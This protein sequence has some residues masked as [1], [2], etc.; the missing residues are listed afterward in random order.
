ME[1]FNFFK[2][3]KQFIVTIND[4]PKNSNENKLYLNYIAKE[5]FTYLKPL[6]FK[7]KG[8]TFNRQAEAGLYQVINIQSGRYYKNEIQG[9]RESYYGKFTIN[10]GVLVEELYNLSYQNNKDF[11]YDYECQLRI[12]L[13]ELTMKQDY[14][15]EITDN[16]NLIYKEIINGLDAHGLLWL[17]S[18]DTREKICKSWGAI[19]G[20]SLRAKL[21]VALITIQKDKE[22]GKKLLQDYYDR[23]EDSDNSHKKY[24]KEFSQK[25]GIEIN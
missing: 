15:W 13:S 24:V 2:K 1:F 22:K 5:I 10:L 17:N 6:G 12:R 14:W 20:S 25:L 21:D 4:T 7:K 16:T 9:F 18:F 8:S 3:K 23:I 19:E 11:Y